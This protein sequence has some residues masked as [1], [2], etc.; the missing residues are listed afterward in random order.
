MVLGFV[1]ASFLYVALDETGTNVLQATGLILFLL[2]WLAL[3][4][5]TLYQLIQKRWLRGILMALLFLII[6]PLY[7]HTQLSLLQW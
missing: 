1:A 4:G 3:L 5:S 6:V 2:S 7:M